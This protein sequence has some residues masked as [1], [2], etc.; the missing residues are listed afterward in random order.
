MAERL[1]FLVLVDRLGGRQRED[2]PLAEFRHHVVIVGVEPLGHLLRGHAVTGVM[3]MA[4]RT[5]LGAAFRAARHRKIGRERHATASPAVD[6]RNGADH[7]T[8]VEHMIVQREIVGRDD[9]HPARLLACPVGGTQLSRGCEQGFLIDLARP[10]AF[11]CGFQ[12]AARTDAR[13]TKRGDSES[14]RRI[15]HGFET[16]KYEKRRG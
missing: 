7:R 6:V 2:L 11:Q 4:V 1:G 14:D 5:G 10:E 12:F 13:R 3:H 15:R 16:P 9:A 8:G